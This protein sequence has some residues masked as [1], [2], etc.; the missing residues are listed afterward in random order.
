M[1]L[2]FQ[3]FRLH[4]GVEVLLLH[5]IGAWS[6]L[7]TGHGEPT[8]YW[9]WSSAVS[10]LC[11]Q[12]C[13]SIQRLTE[14]CFLWRLQYQDAMGR[15]IWLLFLMVDVVMISAILHVAGVLL[16]HGNQCTVFCSTHLFDG[17][18]QSSTIRSKVWSQGHFKIMKSN[19][20]CQY[21]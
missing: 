3:D 2:S 4:R 13:Y 19:S 8:Y 21:K 10:S 6:V 9:S 5:K 15:S 7:A 11:K 18:R 16:W 20:P 14:L 17:S 12:K 1:V